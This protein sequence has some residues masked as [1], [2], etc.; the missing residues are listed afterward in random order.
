MCTAEQNKTMKLLQEELFFCQ[1]SRNRY[2]GE[3]EGRSFTLCLWNETT[4]FD[5]RLKLTHTEEKSN[6]VIPE[7][8]FF[9]PNV[10]P[11]RPQRTEEASI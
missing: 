7:T 4:D 9:Q 8:F 5:V 1:I 10:S 3:G 2:E 11:T 6:K